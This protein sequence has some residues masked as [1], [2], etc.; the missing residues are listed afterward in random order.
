MDKAE[1]LGLLEAPDELAALVDEARELLRTHN[2]P[3]T[4]TE[5][6]YPIDAGKITGMILVM[7]CD[8]LEQLI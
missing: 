1:I 8:F 6:R 3:Y 2:K 4:Y 5:R 7:D